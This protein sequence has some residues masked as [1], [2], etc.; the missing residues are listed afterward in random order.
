MVENSANQIEQKIK[1][2]NS[3]FDCVLSH[4]CPYNIRPTHL[5]LKGIDQ[6]TVDSSMEVW[7]QNIADHIELK[8]WY[9][10]HFPDD[11]DN[12]QYSMLYTDIMEFP[13]EE[14]EILLDF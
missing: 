14:E 1:S 4:T 13:L 6:S 3:N 10:G 8:R 7:L 9:F 12:G 5:F 2:H 11:W